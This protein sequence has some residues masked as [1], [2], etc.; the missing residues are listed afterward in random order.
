MTCRGGN[1]NIINCLWAMVQ[2]N[3]TVLEPHKISP[4]SVFESQCFES[5]FS[6]FFPALS[7]KIKALNAWKNNLKLIRY[8]EELH[9]CTVTRHCWKSFLHYIVVFGIP[10][11]QFLSYPDDSWVS[12]LQRAFF[13][14]SYRICDDNFLCLRLIEQ[15]SSLDFKRMGKLNPSTTLNRS[16]NAFAK[17]Q[18]RH[19]CF[20]HWRMYP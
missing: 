2:K 4:R 11:F 9:S 5:F 8:W 12:V 14:Y 17:L 13:I 7:S 20:K 10:I 3:K 16:L 18:R 19:R 6:T 15:V 1:A